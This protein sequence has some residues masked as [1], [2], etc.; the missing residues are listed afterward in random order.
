MESEWPRK[1][2]NV[3]GR[4]GDER[5]HGWE[6]ILRRL[7]TLCRGCRSS[8]RTSLWRMGS[9]AAPLLSPLPEMREN[10]AVAWPSIKFFDRSSG[11]LGFLEIIPRT[12]ES[13]K[14]RS[15]ARESGVQI[16]THMLASKATIEALSHASKLQLEL[17][18]DMQVSDSAP[19]MMVGWLFACHLQQ[20]MH[21]IQDLPS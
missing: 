13:R 4:C 14:M 3:T 15:R 16:R 17:P 19:R 2:G 18:I 6:A 1:K 7:Y 8:L 5:C 21:A 9:T 20:T 12:S 11:R 10:G